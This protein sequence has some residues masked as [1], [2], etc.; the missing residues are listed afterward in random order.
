MQIDNLKLPI[1]SNPT[2]NFLNP[3]KIF[4]SF[5][6]TP[7]EEK[8]LYVYTKTSND[9]KIDAYNINDPTNVS[10]LKGDEIE[11]CTE[12]FI[13]FDP[14]SN[15]ESKLDCTKDFKK[16]KKD[17]NK[18]WDDSENN[19]LTEDSIK[20]S[21]YLTLIH[22]KYLEIDRKIPFFDYIKF[23][24]SESPQIRQIRQKPIFSSNKDHFFF[25]LLIFRL[26][27]YTE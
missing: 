14:Q 11:G 23:S 8:I 20:E 3:P 25:K 22:K 19:R 15:T 13:H 12:H 26:Q 21:E 9:S 10:L 16:Y 2:I 1:K 24:L 5:Q 27:L 18:Y 6:V 4:H 17:L 7:S